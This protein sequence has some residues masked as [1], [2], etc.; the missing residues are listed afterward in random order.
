[1]AERHQMNVAVRLASIERYQRLILESEDQL[2]DIPPC[3]FTT[4]AGDV[5][6]TEQEKNRVRGHIATYRKCIEH[7][8]TWE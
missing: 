2:K 8:S 4:L 3:G 1:M 7:L 6:T 5:D